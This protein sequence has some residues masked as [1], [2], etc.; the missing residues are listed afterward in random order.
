L[1]SLLIEPGILIG[2]NNYYD[3]ANGAWGGF[4]PNKTEVTATGMCSIFHQHSQNIQRNVWFDVNYYAVSKLAIPHYATLQ[5]VTMGEIDPK[6]VGT[7]PTNAP[8]TLEQRKE[9]KSSK[10][11]STRVGATA[12]TTNTGTTGIIIYDVKNTL[13]ATVSDVKS[14]ELR[15][16][17]PPMWRRQTPKVSKDRVASLRPNLFYAIQAKY[18]FLYFRGEIF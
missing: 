5:P 17:L 6:E 8:C 1:Y 7:I 11:G 4:L 18:E 15:I 3:S 9:L 14:R 12:L 13:I 16:N 10:L 2:V